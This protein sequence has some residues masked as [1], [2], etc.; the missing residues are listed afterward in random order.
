MHDQSAELTALPKRLP[1]HG[2]LVAGIF[3]L[4]SL[5]AAFDYAM[6]FARGAEYFRASG[7]NEDQVAYF[8]QLPLWVLLGWTLSVWGGL[9]AALALLARSRLS[10]PLFGLSL[11]GGLMYI[12]YTLVLS[13]GRE[14]MGDVWFMPLLIA[15]FTAGLILYCQQLQQRRFLV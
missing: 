10:R 15:A 13:A 7:M 5:G 3:L 9:L 8:S 11:V 2:W 4:Y 1:W 12:V 14:A 6:S